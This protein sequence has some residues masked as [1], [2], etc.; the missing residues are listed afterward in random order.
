MHALSSMAVSLSNSTSR[1]GKIFQQSL[2]PHH[3]FY[4]SQ[5]FFWLINGCVIKI[6]LELAIEEF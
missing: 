4:I 1:S 6:A 3:K 5:H 2:I